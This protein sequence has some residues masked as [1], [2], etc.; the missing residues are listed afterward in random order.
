MNKKHLIRAVAERSGT[1]D[2]VSTDVINAFWDVITDTVSSEGRIKAWG[3]IDVTRT[4]TKERQGF[5]PK[6]RQPI[7]IPAGHSLR[8]KALTSLKSTVLG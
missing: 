8:V 6:T 5:N 4:A 3:M 1:T 2:A 7:T